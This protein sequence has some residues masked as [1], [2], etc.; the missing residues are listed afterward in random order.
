MTKQ[1]AWLLAGGSICLVIA[2]FWLHPVVGFATGGTILIL[3]AAIG[4][5][6]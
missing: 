6:W 4:G 5:D 1:Q 2:G 3:A